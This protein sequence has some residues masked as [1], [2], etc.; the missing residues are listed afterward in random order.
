M[1]EEIVGIKRDV[2]YLKEHTNYADERVGK[3]DKKL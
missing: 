3:K 1:K 2:E